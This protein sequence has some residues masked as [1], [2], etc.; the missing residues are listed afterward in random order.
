MMK[1][2][3]TQ[4]QPVQTVEG[5]IDEPIRRERGKLVWVSNIHI[6]HSLDIA[7]WFE[8]AAS[9]QQLGWQVTLIVEGPCE[10]LLVNGVEVICIHGRNAI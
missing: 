4:A 8:T 2:Q 10:T 1:I 3:A 9:L 5:H 7:T 6:H